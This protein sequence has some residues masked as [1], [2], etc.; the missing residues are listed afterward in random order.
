MGCLLMSSGFKNESLLTVQYTKTLLTL[1][2]IKYWTSLLSFTIASLQDNKLKF[3]MPAFKLVGYF[4]YLYTNLW[5]FTIQY[6]SSHPPKRLGDYLSNIPCS[7]YC[8]IVAYAYVMA[9][10]YLG[11]DRTWNLIIS[12]TLSTIPLA[13]IDIL[14][15]SCNLVSSF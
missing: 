7:P 6:L 2:Y 12:S 14:Y 3:N 1:I 9:G 4:S 5:F 8:I 11:R 15:A 13:I 10:C